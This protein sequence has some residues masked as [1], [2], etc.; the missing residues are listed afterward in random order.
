MKKP[1]FILFFL[2][3]IMILGSASTL[4]SCQRPPE[5]DPFSRFRDNYE[6]R[7]GLECNGVSSVLSCKKTEDTLTLTFEAP[8]TL[9]GYV[10][11]CSTKSADNAENADNTD[12]TDSFRLSYDNVSIE[13]TPE[14]ARLPKIVKEIFAAEKG[15]ITSISAENKGGDADKSETDGMLTSVTANGIIYIFASDGTFKS[16]QGTVLGSKVKLSV[17]D[18]QFIAP[19]SGGSSDKSGSA[20]E[21][22]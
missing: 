4:V 15:D 22:N 18:I 17:L 11:T 8:E 1:R 20:A 5:G 2:I 16:A 12:N 14:L 9:R 21:S 13:L 3:S 6:A 7:F 19:T 10:F